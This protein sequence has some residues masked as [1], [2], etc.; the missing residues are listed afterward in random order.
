MT[1][2]RTPTGKENAGSK[3]RSLTKAAKGLYASVRNAYSSP[4]RRPSHGT[5]KDSTPLDPDRSP[6]KKPV[7]RRSSVGNLLSLF[8]N[9]QSSNY[10]YPETTKATKEKS[11]G[12]AGLFGHVAMRRRKSFGPFGS[13]TYTRREPVRN[14]A[15]HTGD[16][17]EAISI[18][19]TNTT[20]ATTGHT[21]DCNEAVSIHIRE[22]SGDPELPV[23][24]LPLADT[25]EATEACDEA[26][27]IHVTEPYAVF[28]SNGPEDKENAYQQL[29]ASGNDEINKVLSMPDSMRP[30]LPRQNSRASTP[31]RSLLG[32]E[33]N[34]L[35]YHSDATRFSN[36][37]GEEIDPVTHL[38]DG[39]YEVP[40][41]TSDPSA[42]EQAKSALRDAMPMV[43]VRPTSPTSTPV[44][45]DPE[46]KRRHAERT[47][48]LIKLDLDPGVSTS[49]TNDTSFSGNILHLSRNIIAA[50]AALVLGPNPAAN[51]NSTSLGVSIDSR[52]DVW[53]ANTDKILEAIRSTVAKMTRNYHGSAHHRSLMDEGVSFTV[54]DTHSQPTPS[55][56]EFERDSDDFWDSVKTGEA[57]MQR[58]LKSQDSQTSLSAQSEVSWFD[59]GFPADIF[60]LRS[61]YAGSDF[62]L[63][64]PLTPAKKR[65]MLDDDESSSESPGYLDVFRHFDKDLFSLP[66]DSILQNS[67]L[68]RTPLD[69][70][71]RGPARMVQMSPKKVVALPL[72]IGDSPG[73]DKLVR[74]TCPGNITPFKRADSDEIETEYIEDAQFFPPGPSQVSLSDS[75]KLV[76]EIVEHP[77]GYHLTTVRKHLRSSSQGSQSSTDNQS[78]VDIF[79][80]HG[81]AVPYVPCSSRQIAGLSAGSSSIGKRDDE[82]W[83]GDTDF[84]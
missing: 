53:K 22:P 84:S 13:I 81:H 79:L 39:C 26:V 8:S 66:V 4:R 3:Y 28:E 35:L 11:E 75:V 72:S 68:F 67:I 64:L 12:F 40:A 9:S 78:P 54:T 69:P 37:G 51:S 17:N 48:K 32:A 33:Q 24:N 36:S 57:I 10:E 58:T 43:T 25:T 23:E 52:T 61:T 41:H 27:S 50:P 73:S 83:T 20:T 19:V 7:G 18:H 38:P 62:S 21:G 77:S 70:F 49:Q 5:W 31:V 55:Y 44:D 15:Q 47:E 65:F 76:E 46:F 42:W 63:P 45:I 34:R 29:V 74:R 1:P 80:A 6:S 30:M 16:C 2:P 14:T 56:S 71:D 82:R 59:H 60:N